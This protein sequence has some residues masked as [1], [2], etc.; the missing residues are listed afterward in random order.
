MKKVL[1]TGKDS[2][3][4]TSLEKWLNKEP[5]NYEVY[6]VD[7][8]DNSWKNEDFSPYDV[9]FHV[10]G[11]VHTKAKKGNE[12][13][14]YE[15]NRDLTLELAIKCKKQ[16]IKQFI[17]LSTMSIYGVDEGEI[18]YETVPVP[19][20]HYGNSKFEA[21]KLLMGLSDEKFRISIVRPPMVYGKGCKGNYIR[22]ANLVKKLPVFPEIDNKR[23]MIYIDNLSEFVKK[24]ILH[25]SEGIF[26]PQN[27]N[28]VKTSDMVNLIAKSHN[29]KIYFIKIFNPVIRK[30]RLNA[31][32]KLF[33]S[34][35]YSKDMSEC[36]FSYNI[37]DFE[38]SVYKSEVGE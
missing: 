30:I 8:K 34:L 14:F 32:I 26:F 19:K 2:Y 33:G 9:V 3:I 17:F 22:L 25:D 18:T 38:S 7:M 21:E 28:Y 13:L 4:G 15:V 31:L 27:K 10:A 20:D 35:Y 29:K 1:I 5:L 37:C 23:S 16:G 11:I 6:T 36:D 24:T 12:K